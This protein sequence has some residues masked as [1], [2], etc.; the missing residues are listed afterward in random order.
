MRQLALRVGLLYRRI[1]FAM[2]CSCRDSVAL[3]AT[4]SALGM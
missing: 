2:S 4:P 3:P 1:P